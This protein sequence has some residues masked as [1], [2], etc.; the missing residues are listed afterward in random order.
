MKKLWERIK[1]YSIKN[2][3]KRILKNY[4]SKEIRRG[5]TYRAYLVDKILLIFLIYFGLSIYLSLKTGYIFLSFY[6]V[7]M[8]LF[9]L[10]YL[11]KIYINRRDREKIK[12]INENLKR[13]KLIRD[14]SNLTRNGF[15][16]FVQDL[17][18]AHFDTEIIETDGDIDFIGTIDGDNFGVKCIKYNM[19]DKVP[20]RELNNFTREL[21]RLNISDGILITNS[22]FR[23][24]VRDEARV[25]IYDFDNIVEML[26]SIGEY[27]S[28]KDMENY[29]IDRFLGRRNSV[30]QQV[31][32]INKKKILQLY[33]I[34]VI[35]YT[36]SFVVRFS[37]YYRIIAVLV[38]VFTTIVVGY[39]FSEYIR[40]KDRYPLNK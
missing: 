24:D 38:F 37:M 22:Y 8:T 15:I 18:V 33:G 1:S 29:I 26:K 21:K 11:I 36:L 35:F 23:D 30:R 16:K 25:I 17:L 14:F 19:D 12:A 28:D 4:Y 7:G 2:N 10:I 32:Q 34:F 9:F 20:L 6:M 5:K 31:R 27:P 13:K 3:N 40:L 39:K